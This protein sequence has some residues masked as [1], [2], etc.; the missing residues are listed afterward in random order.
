MLPWGAVVARAQQTGVV[1]G[2]ITDEGTG[3]PIPGVNVALEGT[4]RGAA[5]DTS[6]YYRIGDVEPGT[7]TVVASFIGYGDEAEQGVEVMAGETT[8]VD[9]MMQEESTGLDEVVVVGYGEQ[10][11]EDLTGSV[12]VVDVEDVESMPINSPAEALQGKVAGVEVQTA[13]GI[14]GGGPRI[15]VRGTGNVGAG[16]QPLYVIDGFA[17]PKPGQGEALARN[18]LADIPA[19][20]IESMT[21]LKGP[22]ATAIYGSRAS[23]GVVLVTTKGGSDGAFNFNVSASTGWNQVMDQM[24][25]NS[26][27]AR[28]FVEFQNY[29]WEGRVQSGEA[30]EIPEVYR[31]PQQYGEGTDWWDAATRTAQRHQVQISAS[32]GSDQMTSYY[33]AGFTRDEGVMLNSN[34]T[35]VSARANLDANLTDRVTVGLKLAPTYTERNLNWEGGSGRA[36]PGGAPWMLCPIPPVR[37]ED[38]SLYVQPGKDCPGVWSHPNPVRW[39][40]EEEDNE[41]TLRALGSAFLDYE[42]I[43][44]LTARTQF[45]V[46][47]R[48][49]KRNQFQPSTIGGINSPPP[50]T[51]TGGLSTSGYLNWLGETTLNWQTELGPG[52]IDALAGV[53]AQQQVSTSSGFSGNFPN[54]EIQTLNVASQIEGF[55]D[56]Q[57]WSLLSGLARVNYS[58]LNRY[59]FTG[60][61]RTDGSSRFGADSRWGTFPSGAVAWTVHNESFM[62]GVAESTVPKVRVRAS[63]GVTGNNQIGN[64]SYLG[65]VGSTDYVF[66]GSAAAGRTLNTMGNPELAWE[67]TREANVGVDVAL[68]DYRLEMSLE[69][70]RRN[71]TQLLLNRTLPG[72]AGFGS[73]TENSG[74]L[75]NQGVEFTLTSRNVEQENYQWSTTF[76]VAVNRNKVLSLPGGE[77][78]RYAGAGPAAYIHREGLP[79]ASYVGYVVDGLYASEEQIDNMTAYPGAVPGSIIFRDLNDDGTITE[80]LMQPAGDFRVLGDAYPDFT[81]SLSNTV[82]LGPFDISAQLTGEFGGDNLRS[83]FF[84]TARNIDGLFVVDEAYIDN[85]W[86]SPEQPGDGLTP[87]PRGGAFGRQQ[88]RDVN[89]SLVLSD[90][91][92]IWLRSLM[93]RYNLG[94]DLFGGGM[95]AGTEV[96]VT[97]NNLFI[98]SPYPGNPD[99]TDMSQANQQPGLDFGNYPLPRTVTF[100]VNVSL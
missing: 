30:G 44:G 81:F 92:H 98:L 2:T 32:G 71:T 77:D 7:Y 79:L 55:S 83:E 10:Q 11:R 90:A 70:Y 17:L 99:V 22:S 9:L 51:P 40:Q 59:L 86:R 47:F 6:G 26:A 8:T 5:T 93:L 64:Y 38:G 12:G 57:E 43:S 68:Y 65:V 25:I 53:T 36:G 39:L 23:S 28:K 4:Q 85:F 89:H 74:E 46:D 58:L 29:I 21:V 24:L 75:R 37:N 16:G 67:K 3:T 63:Y 35:R 49:G 91:S 14:P 1:E 42:F 94:N 50:S 15:Q 41:Q 48:T 34:F 56:E 66:G 33:S 84:R 52:R 27:G 13:T 87:T 78:I 97:G 54:D 82:G 73:V 45:N 88:Y 100:G 18:P 80:D 95:L 76:N 69:M 19:S 60:T 72:V 62:E 96:Y 20:D 61:I 31:N